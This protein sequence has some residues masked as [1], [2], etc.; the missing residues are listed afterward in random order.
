MR[1]LGNRSQA[2]SRANPIR[3]GFGA[4]PAR[5][6]GTLSVSG[7]VHKC[8]ETPVPFG[9]MA[10]TES[11]PEAG[12]PVTSPGPASTPASQRSLPAETVCLE[13]PDDERHVATEDLCRRAADLAGGI[14]T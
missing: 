9:A 11:S 10:T 2:A 3:F 8:S 14:S 5:G 12:G 13:G 7:A 4:R 1:C 6:F